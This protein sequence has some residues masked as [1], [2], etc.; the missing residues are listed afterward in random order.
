MAVD[1]AIDAIINAAR[2]GNIGDGK[3]FVIPVEDGRP[4]PHRRTRR[5]RRLAPHATSG[6]GLS[7]PRTLAP[8]ANQS[9]LR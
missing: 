3:I 5:R 9:N 7:R 1:R 2:T 4:R 6:E 8:V